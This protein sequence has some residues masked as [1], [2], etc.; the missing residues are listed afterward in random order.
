MVRKFWGR[1]LFFFII[2]FL[3]SA[4]IGIPKS[5]HDFGL[6]KADTDVSYVFE[7]ENSDKE[8]LI[9]EYVESG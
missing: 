4:Q 7:I 5:E 6:I 3:V 1:L 2:Y 9:V 8:P